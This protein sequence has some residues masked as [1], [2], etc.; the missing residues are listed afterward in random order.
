[1]ANPQSEPISEVEALEFFRKVQVQLERTKLVNPTDD[2]LEAIRAL[3]ECSD[4][5]SKAIA[6]EPVNE[7]LAQPPISAS[8]KS[9][10][11]NA[12]KENTATSAEDALT[13][14]VDESSTSYRP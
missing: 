5:M 3:V 12:R 8:F 2:A 4:E 9:N 6:N 11:F 14:A 10:F 7:T 1:M 13:P